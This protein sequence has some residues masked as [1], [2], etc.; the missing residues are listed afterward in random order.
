M[1]ERTKEGTLHRRRTAPKIS[2]QA[3]RKNTQVWAYYGN[4]YAECVAMPEEGGRVTELLLVERREGRRC[5]TSGLEGSCDKG[6][7]VGLAG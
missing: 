2:H 6:G 4:S 1:N 7:L 5:G 3:Q